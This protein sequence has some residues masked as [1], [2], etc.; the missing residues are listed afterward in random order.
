MKLTVLS[1]EPYTFHGLAPAPNVTES[2]RIGD[3]LRADTTPPIVNLDGAEL[4]VIESHR[5]SILYCAG[6][7][8]VNRVAPSTEGGMGYLGTPP[9]GAEERVVISTSRG[10]YMAQVRFS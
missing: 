1:F 4:T 9:V 10:Q 5:S 6:N 2:A 8:T 3:A 7:A